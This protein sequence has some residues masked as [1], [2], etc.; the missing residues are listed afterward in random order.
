MTMP[1][2]H[3][4]HADTR[5]MN[6]VD[7]NLGSS[8][9]IFQRGRYVHFTLEKHEGGRRRDLSKTLNYFRH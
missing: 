6:V 9:N 5:E 7:M 4:Q 3:A 8:R 2:I 1:E